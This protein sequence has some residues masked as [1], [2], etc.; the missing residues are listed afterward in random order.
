MFKAFLKSRESKPG[1][2]G[3]LQNIKTKETEI[4]LESS[5]SGIGGS[6]AGGAKKNKGYLQVVHKGSPHSTS[7]FSDASPLSVSRGGDTPQSESR[8]I[9]N[10]DNK[11]AAW[12]EMKEITSPPLSPPTSPPITPTFFSSSFHHQTTLSVYQQKANSGDPLSQARVGYCY[13]YNRGTSTIDYKEAFRWYKLA[14][15]QGNPEGQVG[16]GNLYLKGIGES[17]KMKKKEFL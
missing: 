3:S 12:V 13:E 17:L 8:S 7:R 4:G 5:I 14:S 16:L 11:K 6:V 9:P 10:S 15:D 1:R 2:S